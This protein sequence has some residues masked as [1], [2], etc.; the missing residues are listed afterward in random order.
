MP[1]CITWCARASC[2]RPVK[3]ALPVL[4]TVHCRAVTSTYDSAN[5]TIVLK[6]QCLDSDSI[7]IVLHAS[8]PVLE[9]W[10]RVEEMFHIPAGYPIVEVY[11]NAPSYTAWFDDLRIHPFQGNMKS[12]AY[13]QTSLRLMAEL[14]ENNFATFYEYDQEGQL[15][16]VKKE[17]VKGIVTLK[18]VRSQSSTR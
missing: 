7:V 11:L 1:S 2:M 8:G 14:D 6:K 10:Q 15:M 13:D 12:Y 9:E 16:R 3:P 5:V 17:T 18:E 4:F